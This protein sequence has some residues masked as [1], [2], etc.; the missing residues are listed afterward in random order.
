MLFALPVKRIIILPFVACFVI[1]VAICFHRKQAFVHTGTLEPTDL[2]LSN[3]SNKAETKQPD[4]SS[5]QSFSLLGSGQ[6]PANGQQPV[7]QSS[8]QQT[9]A[10]NEFEGLFKT[11]TD[12]NSGQYAIVSPDSLAVVGKGK[13]G[14]TIW[15]A[16]ISRIVRRSPIYS[17]RLDGENLVIHD[18][19]KVRIWINRNTGAVVGFDRL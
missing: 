12:Q 16:D 4:L 6:N 17:M 2:N 7:E 14:E 19:G 11:I 5:T 15:R 3:A 18:S 8:A 9:N 10:A 13:G 1:A